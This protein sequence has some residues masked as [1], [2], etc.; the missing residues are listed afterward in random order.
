[1]LLRCRAPALS[2]PRCCVRVAAWPRSAALAALPRCC[3]VAL[4]RC[5]VLLSLSRCC[6]VA[7]LLPRCCVRVVCCDRCCVA[8]SSCCRAAASLRCCVCVAACQVALLLRCNVS[9]LLRSRCRVAALSRAA[10]SQ[11][12]REVALLTVFKGGAC[13]RGKRREQLCNRRLPRCCWCSRPVKSGQSHPT[14]SNK[15]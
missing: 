4:L 13:K 3:V 9:A 2:L 6:R 5:R 8:A 10:L 14:R 12:K 15:L 11:L 1:M 7:D